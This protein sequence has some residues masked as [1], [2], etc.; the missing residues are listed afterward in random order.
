MDVMT[1]ETDAE[2]E[3][4]GGIPD[5]GEGDPDSIS[6]AVDALTE[7]EEPVLVV[8]DGV[9]RSDGIKET[10]ELAES[11]GAR[12]HAEIFAAETN[13]PT[14]HEQFVSFLPLDE[15]IVSTF[16][17]TDTLIFVGCSTNTT[18][19]KNEVDLVPEDA[20]IVQASDSGRELGKNAPCDVGVL[21]DPARVC[22]RIARD[23]SE[24]LG[25]D[26]LKERLE[27]VRTTRRALEP[28]MLEMGED[29]A[30]GSTRPSKAELVDAM[31]EQM[32]GAYIADE[33]VTSKYALLTRYELEGNDYLANKGGGLGYGMPAAVGGALAHEDEGSDRRVVGFIGDGSYFY[34]PQTVYTAVREGIDMTF[35]VPDNDGYTILRDNADKMFGDPKEGEEYAYTG[36]RFEPSVDVVGSA[37]SYGATAERINK[38]DELH[39]ALRESGDGVHVVDIKVHD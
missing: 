8:G 37:R 21:G 6:E 34:Y 2:P 3:R 19:W 10:V 5:G 4:I 15:G 16:L 27:S 18:L 28:M 22:R 17:K 11:T 13:F 7:A 23:I 35:V 31:C 38:P 25:G 12:V 26:E 20:T 29:E 39:E 30:E 24:R 36:T 33:G 9:A 32:G 1:A 14:E